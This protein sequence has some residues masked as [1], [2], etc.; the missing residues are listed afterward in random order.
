MLP[1]NKGHALPN[2]VSTPA[3]STESI[4]D[5]KMLTAG[6]ST[7]ADSDDLDMQFEHIFAIFPPVNVKKLTR[8]VISVLGN[9]G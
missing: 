3:I 8:L 6:L 9:P 1:S 2:Y 4:I 7:S 5:M